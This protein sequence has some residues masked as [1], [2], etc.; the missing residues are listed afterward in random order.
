MEFNITLVP[1]DRETNGT[2]CPACIQITSLINGPNNVERATLQI[3]LIEEAPDGPIPPEFSCSHHAGMT[4]AKMI[5]TWTSQHIRNLHYAHGPANNETQRTRITENL[6]FADLKDRDFSGQNLEFKQMDGADLSGANLSRANLSSAR[7]NGVNLTGANL[8]GTNLKGASLRDADFKSA[9]ITGVDLRWANLTGAKLAGAGLKDIN[10]FGANLSR[11]N[12]RDADLE[13]ATLCQAKLERTDLHG[14]NLSGADLTKAN[15]RWADLKNA[16]MDGTKLSGA[17]LTGAELSDKEEKTEER[18]DTS[19][20]AQTSEDP[21]GKSEENEKC[22]TA[23]FTIDI[24]LTD[25]DRVTQIMRDNQIDFDP[26]ESM[27]CNHPYMFV[28]VIFT[29][30]SARETVEQVNKWLEKAQRP[31][32]IRLEFED[33][34]PVTRRDFLELI[35]LHASWKVNWHDQQTTLTEMDE[36]RWEGF[37]D[38]HL[39]EL[40]QG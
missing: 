16:N 8:S 22:E 5:E 29:G 23:P 25:I 12:L 4:A 18:T 3:Q 6:V 27:V 24:K 11:A 17:D 7:M 38:K 32:R 40:E 28:E 39:Q 20:A 21:E 1:D 35:N 19:E 14:A 30:Q 34:S 10:L 2:L 9:N 26:V 13:N 33:M 31:E 15:L 36:A 37:T